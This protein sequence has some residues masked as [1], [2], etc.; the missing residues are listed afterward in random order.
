MGGSRTALRRRVCCL[1]HKREKCLWILCHS[2][3]LSTFGTGTDGILGP[4]GMPVRRECAWGIGF[5]CKEFKKNTWN[6]P[7]I[8][9]IV[10]LSH[11]TL[12][13]WRWW[14]GVLAPTRYRVSPLPGDY[15]QPRPSPLSVRLYQG[16][17]AVKDPRMLDCDFVSCIEL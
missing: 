13:F 12:H 7:N 2:Q 1:D 6:F 9:F 5:S 4:E 17:V 14:T 3:M 8:F 15:L 10:R 11:W 16:S